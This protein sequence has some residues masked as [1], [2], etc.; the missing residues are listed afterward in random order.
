[1]RPVSPDPRAALTVHAIRNGVAGLAKAEAAALAAA[2]RERRIRR[3]C[4][5]YWDAPQARQIVKILDE[6]KNSASA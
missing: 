1:M 3:I 6:R 4:E 2:D 5:R